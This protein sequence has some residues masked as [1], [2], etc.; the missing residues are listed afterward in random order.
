MP[1]HRLLLYLRQEHH[2]CFYATQTSFDFA[3]AQDLWLKSKC[4]MSLR[5]LFILTI[6]SKGQDVFIPCI[7]LMP[8]NIPFQFKRLQFQVHP[9]CAITINKP[10]GQ[11][12]KIVGLHLLTLLLLP[13]TTAVC[14]IFK[15]WM[16]TK[17]LCVYSYSKNAQH[18]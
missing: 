4:P 2:S 1:P 17:S 7:L 6:C 11:T 5:L 9:S 14:W 8:P 12:W 15:S 13:R 16:F 18:C 3:M 10:Q